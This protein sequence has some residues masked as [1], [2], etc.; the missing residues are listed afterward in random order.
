LKANYALSLPS[1]L[2]LTTASGVAA[3]KSSLANAISTV[4]QIYTDMTTAPSTTAS[5]GSTGAAPAYLT[6]EIANYQAALERLQ[7][8]AASS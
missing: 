4:K 3:A 5:H 7:S 2:N 8:A 6:T 1:T